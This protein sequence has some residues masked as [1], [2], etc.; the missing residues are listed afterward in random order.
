ML[1]EIQPR[2]VNPFERGALGFVKHRVV[3]DVILGR[4]ALMCVLVLA[5][6]EVPT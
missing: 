4:P 6:E 2:A 1:S 3:R 5:G